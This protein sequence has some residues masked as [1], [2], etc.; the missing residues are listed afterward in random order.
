MQAPSSHVCNYEINFKRAFLKY[1]LLSSKLPTVQQCCLER[2][3]YMLA[4]EMGRQFF[5]SRQ[6]ISIFADAIWPI[7]IIK[8]AKTKQTSPNTHSHYSISHQEGNEKKEGNKI[9]KFPYL[10]IQIT[11][12][13]RE[14]PGPA[15]GVKDFISMLKF[16]PCGFRRV[17]CTHHAASVVRSACVARKRKYVKWHKWRP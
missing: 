8:L 13:S 17:V 15:A 4:S 1:L 12:P 2:V 6:F 7:R 10:Q 16:P 5:K 9:T 3:R 14:I 11:I